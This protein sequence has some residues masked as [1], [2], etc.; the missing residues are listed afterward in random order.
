M[1]E[2]LCGF[3]SSLGFEAEQAHNNDRRT[4]RLIAHEFSLHS[5]H[6]ISFQTVDQEKDERCI[7]SN[8]PVREERSAGHS[9]S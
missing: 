4:N 5:P 9:C 1:S 6:R 7:L 3:Q 8:V 2:P